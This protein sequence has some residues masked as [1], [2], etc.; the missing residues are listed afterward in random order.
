MIIQVIETGTEGKNKK[1]CNYLHR[2]NNIVYNNRN[3]ENRHINFI[4][5]E[6]KLSDMLQ[7]DSLDTLY[8]K[9]IK[10]LKLQEPEYIITYS[11]RNIQDIKNY[12]KFIRRRHRKKNIFWNRFIQKIFNID[13]YSCLRISNFIHS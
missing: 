3:Y 2:L 11:Y 9:I 4:E 10:I 5:Y 1:L 12:N 8:D 6:N 13:Y 7:G